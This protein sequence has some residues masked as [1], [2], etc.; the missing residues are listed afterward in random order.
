M[1]PNS[2]YVR[3]RKAWHCLKNGQKFY[4][5]KALNNNNDIIMLS[6]EAVCVKP[7]IK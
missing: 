1:I 7:V 6:I 2:G 5:K 4:Y 3:T